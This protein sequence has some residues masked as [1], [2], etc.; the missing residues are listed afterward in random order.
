M[1]RWRRQATGMGAAVAAAAMA[2]V[3]AVAGTPSGATAALTEAIVNQVLT[4][5]G[6]DVHVNGQRTA[7]RY[8]GAEAP[9][10]PQPCGPEAL[11]RNRELAGRRVMLEEDPRY[12]YDPDGA[13]LFYVYAA[14]GQSI[15]AALIREGLARAVRTAAARGG[16]LAAAEAEAKAAGRGCLW[17]GTGGGRTT[18][19]ARLTGFQE[20]PSI[21]TGAHGRFRA[22]IHRDRIDFELRYDGLEGRVT[23][24]HVHLGRRHSAG[25]VSAFLCGGGGA[26]ACPQSG[27]VRGTI[28]A[29]DVIGPADQGIGPGEFR[30]V[31]RAIGAAATYANV[32]S[33]LFPAGEIRGQLVRADAPLD[34]D[35]ATE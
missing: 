6:L 4:G 21:S 26:P 15:D 10:P 16:E 25:G 22:D 19:V 20:T 23:V 2:L 3:A 13:R 8:L 27:T 7:I 14:D 9:F 17:A 32:H 35:D 28:V 31:A 5:D 34:P 18:V 11:A 30:E 33:S 24:A 1:K 12:P 29:A